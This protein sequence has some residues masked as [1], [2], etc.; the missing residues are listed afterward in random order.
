MACKIKCHDIVI[1]GRVSQPMEHRLVAPETLTS[2][3]YNFTTATW[4]WSP[5]DGPWLFVQWRLPTCTWYN[6]SGG[7]WANTLLHIAGLQRY[8][9]EWKFE[10]CPYG[11]LQPM[12]KSFGLYHMVSSCSMPTGYSQQILLERC[13][14]RW[15]LF[16]ALSYSVNKIPHGTEFYTESFWTISS[17]WPV[18]SQQIA[19]PANSSYVI[20]VLGRRGWVS[21]MVH[22][23]VAPDS[24]QQH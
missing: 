21:L 5:V 6:L 14:V 23:P 4:D 12:V 18:R 2:G 13:H 9:Y 24:E 15:S 22:R 19:C 7:P 1:L 10:N 16:R 20:T 3:H 17:E 8:A 11:M